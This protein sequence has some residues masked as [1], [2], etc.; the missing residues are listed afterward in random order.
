MDTNND[1]VLTITDFK[2]KHRGHFEEG[3]AAADENGDG[4]LDEKEFPAMYQHLIEKAAKSAEDP[5]MSIK[6]FD[7]DEDGKVSFAELEVEEPDKEFF[8]GIFAK[9]DASGDGLLDALELDALQKLMEEDA[10]SKEL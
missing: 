4:K 8:E 3:F 9:A 6:D 7:K 1:G 2:K 10:A 5:T